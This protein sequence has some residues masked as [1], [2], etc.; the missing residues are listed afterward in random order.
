ML[1][2]GLSVYLLLFTA[3][4]Y[5]RSP[6]IWLFLYHRPSVRLPVVCLSVTFVHPTRAIEIFGN[7][8]TPSVTLAI[9]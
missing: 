5:P 6:I 3:S 4:Y 7:I 1:Y 8:S 2:C 9:C